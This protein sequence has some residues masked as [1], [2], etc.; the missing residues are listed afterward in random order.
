MLSYLFKKAPER[1]A[2]DEP[3]SPIYFM[4]GQPVRFLSSAAA[5]TAEIAVRKVPQLYRITNFVSSA[6]QSVP[7][8]CEVDNDVV[9]MEQAGASSIKA[10]N[11]LLKSP[12]DSFTATNLQYWIALNLLLY[13]R[14]HFKVGVSSSGLPNGIY[15]LAAKYIRGILNNRGTV[16]KYEYGLNEESKSIL[17][18]RRTAEKTGGG[19]AYAAE[20]SFPSITGLVE[21]NKTPAAIE[22]ITLPIMIIQAL[23]QRAFD[24]AS[25]HPNVKYIITAEKTLTVQQKEAVKK[26][27]EE[28]APGNEDSG[29]ILFLYNTSITVHKLDNDLN[30]IHSKL[31]LD[32]MT[33]QIA[34]V[35]GV[36]IALLGLGSADAAK[37]ANNYAESRLSFWQD[38]IVPCYLRP[39]ATGM[40]AALCPAGARICFDLDDIP[41]L[42]EGRAKLGQVLGT[43]P[44]MTD[45]EKRATLDFEPI[46]GGEN[47]PPRPP[48][49]S[50]ATDTTVKP[51]GSAYAPDDGV[52]NRR[53]LQ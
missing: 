31:P 22:S 19:V 41:A 10:I 9:A 18:T 16:E 53:P 37:Y 50:P 51:D 48:K 17:P 3:V 6:I 36:P 7:W 47:L 23:M 26:H 11:S 28:A 49:E 27:L 1:I 8:Y 4:A 34:G 44:F 43:V 42:W 29:N 38:T 30:D 13:A 39:I 35:F 46:A 2:S 20:I 40:T 12:N 45:N 21:Y 33:R 32:D 25:G 52:T 24:T 5:M 14:A 15:P